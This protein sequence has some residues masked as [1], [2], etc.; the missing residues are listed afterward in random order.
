MDN[1]IN[2]TGRHMD[3]LSQMVLADLHRFQEILQQDLPRVNGWKVT[4]GHHLTSMIV[5]NFHVIGIT[6]T[7]HKA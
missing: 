4:L 2:P 1:L 3:R 6:V 5:H 7:P